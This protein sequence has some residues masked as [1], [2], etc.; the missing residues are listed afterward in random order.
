MG[1]T[2]VRRA[3]CVTW[4]ACSSTIMRIAPSVTVKSKYEIEMTTYGIKAFPYSALAALAGAAASNSGAFC[5]VEDPEASSFCRVSAPG[6]DGGGEYD[7]GI[8]WSM[9]ACITPRERM[10]SCWPA[11]VSVMGVKLPVRED[12]STALVSSAGSCQSCRSK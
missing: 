12:L 5:K 10:A 11:W 7:H 6:G 8:C 1:V 3:C 2:H 9:S 4:Y